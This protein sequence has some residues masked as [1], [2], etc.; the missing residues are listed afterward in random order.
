MKL[1]EIV[2]RYR[3][4]RRRF[5]DRT[6][7]GSIL[8]EGKIY[9]KP[10]YVETK[11]KTGQKKRE[12]PKQS[13][14]ENSSKEVKEERE[15]FLSEEVRD[16]VGANKKELKVIYRVTRS[17]A[18]IEVPEFSN[19]NTRESYPKPYNTM[20]FVCYGPDDWNNEYWYY[21][22]PKIGYSSGLE[23]VATMFVVPIK[24]F[25]TIALLRK[26]RAAG[27]NV[28]KSLTREEVIELCLHPSWP[29][30]KFSRPWIEEYRKGNYDKGPSK[31]FEPII[32]KYLLKAKEHYS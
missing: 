19:K 21:V 15:K 6:R 22:V 29:S 11:K 32:Q 8:T 28:N 20:P 13:F 2:E 27:K 9:S 18:R 4:E 26:L 14:N 24:D 3:Q 1:R 7:P 10:S 31:D 30:E 12:I 17:M 25:V 23:Q 5:L 16:F